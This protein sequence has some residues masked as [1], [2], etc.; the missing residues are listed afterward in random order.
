MC[1]VRLV[2]VVCC[3]CDVLVMWWAVRMDGLG[4]MN[5]EVEIEITYDV[6]LGWC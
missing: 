5:D 3:P 1:V 4:A 2:F 6:L